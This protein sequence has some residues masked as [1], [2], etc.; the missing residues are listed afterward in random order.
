MLLFLTLAFRLARPGLSFGLYL[1]A[2]L[3]LLVASAAVIVRL[4]STSFG[5][6][7]PPPNK[8]CTGR[9]WTKAASFLDHFQVEITTA[10]PRKLSLR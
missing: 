7:E 1:A 6:D 10:L 9:F 4:L 2:V 5:P 8:R 3:L